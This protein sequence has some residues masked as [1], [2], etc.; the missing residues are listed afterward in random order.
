MVTA[1]STSS[2]HPLVTTLKRCAD[3]QVGFAISVKVSHAKASAKEIC[4]F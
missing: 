2:L 4:R 3:C 1:T